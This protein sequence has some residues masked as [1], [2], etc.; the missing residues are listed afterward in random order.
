MDKRNTEPLVKQPELGPKKIYTSAQGGSYR[1]ASDDPVDKAIDLLDELD[2]GYG[3]LRKGIETRDRAQRLEGLKIIVGILNVDAG[4]DPLRPVKAMGP[5]FDAAVAAYAEVGRFL[6]ILRAEHPGVIR[7][8]DMDRLNADMKTAE[9]TNQIKAVY[10][11][12]VT[13][14]DTLERQLQGES[15]PTLTSLYFNCRDTIENHADL[16]GRMPELERLAVGAQKDAAANKANNDRVRAD[17]LKKAAEA[18]PPAQPTAP[19][20]TPT[21]S[22]TTGAATPATPAAASAPQQPKPKPR[23]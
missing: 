6:P 11:S 8:L 9:E 12:G 18:T 7:R 2:R 15:V 17:T 3:I 1:P 22:I 5:N 23:G 14:M 20:A 10:Q 19:A 13:Q 4:A 16:K 21:V